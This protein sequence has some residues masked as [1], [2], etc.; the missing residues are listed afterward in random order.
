M[1]LNLDMMGKVRGIYATLRF[2]HIG[3][4]AWLLALLLPPCSRLEGLL[5]PQC[6]RTSASTAI[7][8]TGYLHFWLLAPSTIPRPLA[9]MRERIRGK[10]KRGS[11]WNPRRPSLSPSTSPITGSSTLPPILSP[12]VTPSPV[13]NKRHRPATPKQ[14]SLPRAMATI[15]S[16][17]PMPQRSPIDPRMQFFASMSFPASSSTWRDDP[18]AVGAAKRLRLHP[19]PRPDR[20]NFSERM[21][22]LYDLV[23]ELRREVADL[24]FRFQA[25]EDNVETFLQILSTMQMGLS[26]EPA[27]MAPGG[28]LDIGLDEMLRQAAARQKEEE[29][30][31]PPDHTEQEEHK[32]QREEDQ[33]TK[34]ATETWAEDLGATWLGISSGV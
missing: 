6:K 32:E 28:E 12:S 26:T 31:G 34:P 29:P 20:D 11:S 33:P 17:S 4:M 3:N 25:T 2:P 10:P 13:K 9:Q 16:G 19:P 27:D 23:F 18:R 22:L 30:I 7:R 1:G 21:G 5:P 15:P 8:S 14:S 24:K